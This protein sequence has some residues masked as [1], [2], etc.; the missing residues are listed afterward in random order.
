MINC[1]WAYSDSSS[2]IKEMVHS[3]VKKVNSSRAI[4][5]TPWENMNISGKYIIE[6]IVS[7][8]NKND[9]FLCELSSLNNNVL[10][11][12]GYAISL[13]KPIRLFINMNL[14]QAKQDFDEFG[15][16]STIGYCDYR[17][18][19]EV[20]REIWKLTDNEK[21]TF[22]MDNIETGS[23]Y[24][25]C[26]LMYLKSNTDSD[27]AI[28]LSRKIN[29][30]CKKIIIDDPLEVSAR[31]LP[32]YIAQLIHSKGVI[33]HLQSDKYNNV[34][35]RNAIASFVSGMAYGLQIPLLMIAP[36]IFQ[37]PIDYRNILSKYRTKN[38]CAMLFENWYE[39][40]R[41]R[42]SIDEKRFR[43]SREL[44]DI[45]EL[46]E[47]YIGDSQ[48]ENEQETLGKYFVRT[49]S[50][51]E[52]INAS[53][54][55]FIGRKGTG[56][57]ANLLSLA[58]EHQRNRDH[59]CVLKPID[60]E[61]E[62][63]LEILNNLSNANQGYLI[64]SIWKYLVYTQLVKSIYE[65]ICRYPI[66]A[67]LDKPEKNIKAFVEEHE[68]LIL[69]EF[70]MRVET[71]VEELKTV[72]EVEEESNKGYKLRVSEML[73]S[74]II[75]RLRT[76]IGDYCVNK[77][78][79]V[80]LIDNLDKAWKYGTSIEMLSKFLFGLLDVGNRI[81][82]DFSKEDRWRKPV[83]LSMIVFLREDIFSIM[84]RYIPERDKV[85]VSRI[86][87]DNEELLLQVIENRFQ[88]GRNVDV[89]DRFFCE[90]VEKIPV[91]EYL[92]RNTLPWPRDLITL[93]KT[94]LTNAVTRKH[95]RIEEKDITDAMRT[96]SLF[97]FNTLVTELAPEFHD[98]REFL[99]EFMNGDRIVLESE[100][101]DAMDDVNVDE[102]YRDTLLS[103]LK[104]MSFWGLE[105]KENNFMF[106]YSEEQYV[107]YQSAAKKYC[108]RNKINNPRYL[109]H[110]AFYIQLMIE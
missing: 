55:I 96:Y 102:T 78:K 34:K 52:A 90:F 63:I 13:Q 53:L 36:E 89:W 65:E 99:Y 59:V 29:E 25:D 44:R 110:P 105:I 76:L 37:T 101:K 10:F 57:T 4:F 71:I 18:S 88:K 80:I 64:E 6:E 107:R 23:P 62:G 31:P 16:L 83:V 20:E 103:M 68:D 97:A 15:L 100:I 45:Y 86:L 87:W 61:I 92:I 72:S 5:I 9:I 67:E 46:G 30:R 32:W 12:L 17:N 28:A 108:N 74:E 93:V 40:N 3:V 35:Y 42:F 7:Q 2:D 8:I 91:K 11:E 49:N 60:Y 70:S 98:I 77:N 1:F 66:H 43:T 95:T 56:K 104:K 54:S 85:Q 94:A 50:Y 22:L 27:D 19:I 21:T 106:C 79:V 24:T 41:T 39:N 26:I 33:T 109:I 82:L 73:H 75:N 84:E 14:K 47:L 48:A 69:V 51:L 81:I 58:E 38:E